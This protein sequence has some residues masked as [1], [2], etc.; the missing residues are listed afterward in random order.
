MKYFFIETQKLADGTEAQAIY[1]KN[2]PDEAAAAFH[3]SMA[4]AM[5]SEN[6]TKAMCLVADEDGC[7]YRSEV[8]ERGN[9]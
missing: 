2:S 9:D 5:Q 7:L 3:A 8:W 4:Y 1:A 6:V